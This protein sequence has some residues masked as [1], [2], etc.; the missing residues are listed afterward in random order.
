MDSLLFPIIMLAVTMAGGG[1]M[2][3]FLK[4]GKKHAQSGG[5]IQQPA[6][7]SSLSMW[8]IS[9]GSACIPVTVWYLTT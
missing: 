9:G 8:Q 1:I 3:L 2:L 5:R 7:R 6:L 4:S